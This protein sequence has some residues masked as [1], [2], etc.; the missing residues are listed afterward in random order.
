M[1]RTASERRS[2]AALPASS[3]VR[4]PI[5]SHTL[6]A[7]A[8]EGAN[9][10]P[11]ARMTNGIATQPRSVLALLVYHYAVGIFASRE[12]ESALWKDAQFR[13]LCHDDFPDWRQLR[14]FRRLNHEAVRKCLMH[15]LA[16]QSHTESRDEHATMDSQHWFAEADRRLTAAIWIDDLLADA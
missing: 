2:P 4:P 9:L 6:R 1:S 5:I 7:V 12:I 8:I 16:A 14:R 10:I 13:A 3:P 15:V 11:V